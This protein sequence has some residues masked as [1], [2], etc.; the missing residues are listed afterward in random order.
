M[1]SIRMKLI[2]HASLVVLLGCSAPASNGPAPMGNV[3]AVP[4]PGAAPAAGE[5]RAVEVLA[6]PVGTCARMSDAT[7]RC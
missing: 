7:V 4:A 3:G 5:D 6:T 2:A 1:P